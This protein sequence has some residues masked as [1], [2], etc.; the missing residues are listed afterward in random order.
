[1]GGEFKMNDISKFRQS[2]FEKIK[3]TNDYGMEYWSAR[4]LQSA[5]DYSTWQKFLA[6]IRKAMLACTNSGAE[7]HDHFNQVV[8]MVGLGSGAKRD[9]IDIE[10]SRYACYL[11]VQNGDSS[12]EVIALGQTYFALQ[13]RKQEFTDDFE[14]LDEDSKRLRIRQDLKNHNKILVDAAKD[15]GVETSLDYGIFQNYGYMGLYGGL[16]AKDIH[17]KK[18]L[19]PSQDI[20]DNM[21]STE[22]A[23]NLFRATQTEDKLRR[24]QIKGK[25][26]ANK[27]HFEVGK[28]VRQ[29]I[30]ELN[31]TMPEELP[32]PTKSIKQIESEKNKKLSIKKE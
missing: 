8:K 25:E 2:L 1:M 9:T 31:G 10:L 11:I 18:G 22:L 20:L 7:V 27:T 13:T 29:T 14:K 21:G 3:K 6:I 28:K 5:L 26:K 17:T 23:A 15:A 12:K 30:Q 19:K 32:T 24:E 4:E 16:K